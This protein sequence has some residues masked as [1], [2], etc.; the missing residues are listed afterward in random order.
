[1]TEISYSETEKNKNSLANFISKES[2]QFLSVFVILDFIQA[3][4]WHLQAKE[5]KGNFSGRLVPKGKEF[6]KCD[7]ISDNF[8]GKNVRTLNMSVISLQRKDLNV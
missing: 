5:R 3:P 2:A 6:Q 7:K 8:F 4:I 1:M